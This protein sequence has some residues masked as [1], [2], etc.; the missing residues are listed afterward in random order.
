MGAEVS[1]W[2]T[3][4]LSWGSLWRTWGLLGATL[5]LFCATS[6]YT[7]LF[8]ENLRATLVNLGLRKSCEVEMLILQWFLKLFEHALWVLKFHLGPRRG[9][10]GLSCED[11]GATWGHLGAMLRHVGTYCGYFGRT[12]GL[13][14][15]T[16]G[17]IILAKWKLLILHLCYKRF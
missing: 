12:R 10:L 4:G 17:F 13:L 14:L 8:F 2:A 5:G 16:L 6:G 1:S 9:Y 7:L 3:S 15:S 11:L